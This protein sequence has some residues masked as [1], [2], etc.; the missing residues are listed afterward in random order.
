LALVVF[1]NKTHRGSRIECVF[2]S[3]EQCKQG[4]VAGT[5]FNNPAYVAPP[6]QAAPAAQT[7]PPKPMKPAKSTKSAKSAKSL[8][9]SQWPQ[10]AQSQ[11]R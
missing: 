6:V 1:D 9:P 8:Q 2:T 4:A 10:P 3:M 7:E 11:Q 5:C